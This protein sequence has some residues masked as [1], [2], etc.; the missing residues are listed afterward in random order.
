MLLLPSFNTLTEKHLSLDLTDPWFLLL[1]LGLTLVTG[2]ISGSYPALFMSSL[3]P[4]VVLKGLLKFKPAATYFRKALVVFQFALS[5]ILILGM[6]VIYRQIDFIH[7][8]NLGF[9]KEDLL[10]MPLEGELQKTYPTFKDQLL[11]Q[12]GIKYVTSAQSSP[13]EVGSST[14]WSTLAR[15]GYYQTD[16]V[17]Q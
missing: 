7:N 9:A 16:P 14:R 11:R 4:I 15:K 17:Q 5:I 12:P 10:Y 6:I 2:I 3:K 8:K 1:L 13:L